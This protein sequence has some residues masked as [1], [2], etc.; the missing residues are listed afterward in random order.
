MVGEYVGE[1]PLPSVFPRLFSRCEGVTPD[2]PSMPPPKKER[3]VGGKKEE[4]AVRRSGSSIGKRGTAV[5]P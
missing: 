1:R 2:G 3:W 5:G 4:Q